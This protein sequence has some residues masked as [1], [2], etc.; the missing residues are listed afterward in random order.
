M[1]SLQREFTICFLNLLVKCFI[2]S[3]VNHGSGGE[4][5]ADLKV[6][7][8]CFGV[9][10]LEVFHQMERIID[11]INSAFNGCFMLIMNDS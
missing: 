3:S 9:K 8:W 6:L 1:K 2:S 11:V 7:S 5:Y 4:V 10:L